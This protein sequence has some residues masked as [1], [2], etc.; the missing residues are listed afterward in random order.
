[1]SEYVVA[2]RW[3]DCTQCFIALRMARIV[4]IIAE[5]TNPLVFYREENSEAELALGLPDGF[6]TYRGWQNERDLFVGRSS[7]LFSGPR[8]TGQSQSR[9]SSQQHAFAHGTKAALLVLIMAR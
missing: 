6:T 4:I 9:I 3:S 7:S 8:K 5:K 2:S 1:V